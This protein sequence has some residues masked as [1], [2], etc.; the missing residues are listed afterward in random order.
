MA[1]K[2]F[3]ALTE[4]TALASSKHS[5]FKMEGDKLRQIERDRKKQK[6]LEAQKSDEGESN[7]RQ[8]KGLLSFFSLFSS[9]KEVYSCKLQ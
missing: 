5:K 9:S 1:D 4:E 6:E 7:N 8:S 3:E 2:K